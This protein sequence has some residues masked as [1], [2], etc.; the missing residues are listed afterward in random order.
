[1]F[2]STLLSE[3]RLERS[4]SLTIHL[5]FGTANCFNVNENSPSALRLG[6][7]PLYHLQ[8]DDIHFSDEIKQE[9]LNGQLG[10]S[11]QYNNY[12]HYIT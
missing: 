7:P 12:S 6:S 4:G 8:P 9:E 3:L 1:M 2:T 5:T 10:T 11:K